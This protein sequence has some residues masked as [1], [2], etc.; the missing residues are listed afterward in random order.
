MVRPTGASAE[1]R[2]LVRRARNRLYRRRAIPAPSP[3]EP[4]WEPTQLDRPDPIWTPVDTTPPL[5]RHVATRPDLHGRHLT[6]YGSEGWGFE[7]LRARDTNVQ[8]SAVPRPES[9]T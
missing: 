2:A 9:P 7:S 4:S 1:V 6:T 3:R 5:S 8:V